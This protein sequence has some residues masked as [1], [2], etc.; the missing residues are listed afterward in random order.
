[1]SCLIQT[2]IAIGTGY[3]LYLILSRDTFFELRR[4]LLIGICVFALSYPFLAEI[5]TFPVDTAAYQPH[6]LPFQLP[7]AHVEA[8]AQWWPDTWTGTGYLITSCISGVLLI[9]FVFQS[10]SLYRAVQ[11]CPRK[12][13]E[14][15]VYYELPGEQAS[16]SFFHRMYICAS[17]AASPRFHAI[18]LHEGVHIR[19]FHTLD[20][21][22]MQLLCIFFW[23]NPI[24][25]LMTREVRRLHEYIAD[26]NAMRRFS[27]RFEYKCALFPPSFH[28][29]AAHLNNFNVSPLKQRIKMLNYY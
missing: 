4:F 9:R 10:A 22:G 3:L 20:V 13:K 23:F 6:I 5:I 24:V 16:F 7:T 21:I 27:N 12:E 1:M 8:A 11:G 29:A 17:D 14:G 26:R 15:H 28:P 25:W 2:N 19:Q 18:C